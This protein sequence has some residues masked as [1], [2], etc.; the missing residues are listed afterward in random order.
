MKKYLFLTV[1]CI[2]S[3]LCKVNAQTQGCLVNGVLYNTSATVIPNTQCGWATP[4]AVASTWTTTQKNQCTSYG[5]VAGGYNQIS[6]PLDDYMPYF[7]VCLAG[8]GAI[9]IRN[10]HLTQSN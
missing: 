8:F 5:G 10:C 7:F 3:Y 4:A 1:L 9:Y 2:F 6:C